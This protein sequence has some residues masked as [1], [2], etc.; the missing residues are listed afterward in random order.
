MDH[1]IEKHG[2]LESAARNLLETLSSDQKKAI[3][4]ALLE[5]KQTSDQD[6]IS[7][8]SDELDNE[9]IFHSDDGTCE[10]L[11]DR[12]LSAFGFSSR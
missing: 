7:L 5:G 4:M 1:E 6:W 2:D 8:R 11:F 3:H 9:L 12:L 10:E